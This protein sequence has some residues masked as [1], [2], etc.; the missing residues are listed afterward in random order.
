M[1]R[2][3]VDGLLMA[4]GKLLKSDSPIAAWKFCNWMM[5]CWVWPFLPLMVIAD[6]TLLGFV[7]ISI[8][9]LGVTVLL[10]LYFKLRRSIVATGIARSHLDEISKGISRSFAASIVV[11]IPVLLGIFFAL[12]WSLAL[13]GIWDS[14]D[15]ANLITKLTTSYAMIALSGYIGW[16]IW[17]RGVYGKRVISLTI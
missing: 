6:K 15:Q 5:L 10:V 14:I 11:A 13:L 9:V 8:L 2:S 1:R 4:I 7:V 12:K 16:L 3:R 17:G